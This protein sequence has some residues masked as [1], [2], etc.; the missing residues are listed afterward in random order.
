MV[1]HYNGNVKL[2]LFGPDLGSF[3]DGWSA[4]D[5]PDFLAENVIIPG[6]LERADLPLYYSGLED[7][8]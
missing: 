5:V 7:N 3:P 6:F 2:F 1:D 8:E 4:G